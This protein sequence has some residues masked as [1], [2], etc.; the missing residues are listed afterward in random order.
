MRPPVFKA[1]EKLVYGLR[2]LG[3]TFAINFMNAF[4]KT[5]GSTALQLEVPKLTNYHCNKCGCR[6]I[7]VEHNQKEI[8]YECMGCGKIHK[9]YKNRLLGRF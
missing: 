1:F 8:I 7:I 3:N 9:A 4:N 6:L 5:F 2:N